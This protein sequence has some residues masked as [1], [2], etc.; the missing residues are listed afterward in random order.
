MYQQSEHNLLPDLMIFW[1]IFINKIQRENC[2]MTMN[3]KWECTISYQF[4]NIWEGS[5]NIGSYI[6]VFKTLFI[7]IIYIETLYVHALV[8]INMV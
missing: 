4:Q 1:D 5:T 8:K 3:L 2:C 6:L 7:L